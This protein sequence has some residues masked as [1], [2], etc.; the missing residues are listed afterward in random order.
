[1][2]EYVIRTQAL[3]RRF[4]R[5]LALDRVNLEVA[6]GNIIALLGPNG[7]GKTTFL[8]VLMGLLEPSEGAA[9]V[10]G[11]DVRAL[12]EEVAVRVGYMADTAEP[13]A[14]LTVGQLIDLKASAAPGFDRERMRDW[15]SVPQGSRYGTLSKGQKKWVRAGTTLA[16]QPDLVL[17]DEPAE[18]LDPSA[19][20]ALYDH[21][22]HY[23][24]E[25]QATAVVTTHVISDI[26]RVADDVAIL[27][28]GTLVLHGLLEDLREEVREVRL[29]QGHKSVLWPGSVDV[30]GQQEDLHETIY[31]VRCS[32]EILETVPLDRAG[33]KPV[34]LERLYFLITE[35]GQSK[36]ELS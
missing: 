21:L 22:R 33:I 31:W 32:P 6:S 1:M 19:R 7:A 13:P 28:Q 4:D 2:N 12:S 3:T 25:H 20:R 24:N 8:R 15:L 9:S 10:F 30:L 29:P 23:V 26:E 35:K 5:T 11:E 18:G 16:A 34:S 27:R 14:W 36:G 17:M